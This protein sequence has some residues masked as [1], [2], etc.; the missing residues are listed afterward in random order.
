MNNA[1][2]MTIKA[3]MANR[4][5]YFPRLIIFDNPPGASKKVFFLEKYFFSINTIEI[6]TIAKIKLSINEVVGEASR[7]AYMLVAR[8][9]YPSNCT[10]PKS[11]ITYKK[12]STDP[13]KAAL[14]IC[15]Q[16]IL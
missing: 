9:G 11:P 5:L 4:Y 12:V 10:T 2:D 3:I 1:K 7:F 14:E 8:F 16:V 6:A 15:G 13:A